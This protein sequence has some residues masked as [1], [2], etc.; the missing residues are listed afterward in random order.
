VLPQLPWIAWA[1]LTCT[2][3]AALCWH[4]AQRK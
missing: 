3:L 2:C 1:A 4:Q